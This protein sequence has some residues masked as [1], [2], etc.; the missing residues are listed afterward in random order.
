MTRADTSPAGQASGAYRAWVLGLLL[1]IYMSNFIDRTIV[2]VLQQPIKAELGLADWQLGMLGG[3]SFAV[4]YTLLGLPIAR[5]A[6]RRNRTPIIVVAVTVWS[7]M[8]GLCGLAQTYA[9]L[10]LARVGVGVGEAG[11]A[12]PA[13]SLI[14]DYFPPERRAT[15]LAIYSLG[16]PLG[17][18][19]GG[20][21]AGLIA[22]HHGWRAA[23][24]AAAIPGVV[25]AVLAQFTLREP[26]RGGL[27][28]ASDTAA[29]PTLMDMARFMLAKPSLVHIVAGST[30]AAFA[31]YGIGGF[32]GAYFMRQFALT[33][34]QAGIL[35]GLIG[36][37]SAML[38]TVLGGTLSD[39]AGKSDPRWRFWTP[40]IGLALAAPLYA[41]A[42]LGSTAKIAACLLIL[43]A[44][45]HYLYLGPT[46]GVLQNMA[47]PRGR[48]TAL[49]L[50]S[51]VVNLVGLG[52]GPLAVGALSDLL[53]ARAFGPT[54]MAALCR[55]PALAAHGAACAAASASG[56]RGAIL[57]TTA[58]FLWAAAH[59]GLAA[60]HLR[61]DLAAG[62][63]T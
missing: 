41:A 2:S 19:V 6:D 4:F 39:R 35:V 57:I 25:L 8:T 15:A 34:G 53:A 55:P 56:L 59:Y 58:L 46:Y 60:R 50:L 3:T 7:V 36:G 54:D 52:L 26:V 49:A 11:G 33:V 61:K 1:L 20:V 14:A 42:Y 47:P 5:L 10:F 37:L 30:V 13:H 12:P 29:A 31:G 24:I 17:A 62:G 45:L 22:Q 40:A 51:L 21:G 27:D 16:L 43:P 28:G 32:N 63:S 18:L 38:G 48:A 23:F 9:Q 44:V